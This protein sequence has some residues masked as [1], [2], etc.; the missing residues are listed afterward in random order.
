MSLIKVILLSHSN[1]RHLQQIYTGFKMLNDQNLIQLEQK[2]VDRLCFNIDKQYLKNADHAILRVILYYNGME[3]KICYDTHDSF[4]II[5]EYASE[6]DFYFKRSYLASY[7]KSYKVQRVKIFPLGLYYLIFSDKVDKFYF[8]RNLKVDHL[9]IIY[10]LKRTIY[11]YPKLSHLESFPQYFL[12]PKVIFQTTAH[13]PYDIKDRPQEKIEE[14]IKLAEFRAS[15]IRYL[16]KELK[17]KAIVGFVHN[18]FT[19][20]KYP[21]LLL[22]DPKAGQKRNYLNLLKQIPICVTTTGLHGSIG[23]KFSEYIALS[24]AIVTEPLNYS[25]PGNL[26]EGQNYLTFSSP[27]DCVTKCIELI[28]NKEL[29]K[30]M[31][32]NN[33]V[34]Y[35]SFL[36]PD[37]L[38]LNTLNIVLKTIV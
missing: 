4:E 36:K 38:V 5:P 12:K 18:K 19:K 11:P 24:K 28:T 32:Y 2:I 9:N 8:W 30:E 35:H 34:Y 33:Y 3:I 27:E 7:V 25:V 23:A 37:K 1:S 15:C 31:M 26:T 10:A 20:R 13:D 22:D 29:M 6:S 17:N 16:R 21:D 14:R